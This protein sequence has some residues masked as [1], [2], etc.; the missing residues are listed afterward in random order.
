MMEFKIE[1]WFEL[2]LKRNVRRWCTVRLFKII[3]LGPQFFNPDCHLIE[4][5][6]VS[7][8]LG[9]TSKPFYPYC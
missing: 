9:Y 5:N 6:S 2:D 1:D 8:S 4:C 7:L 3:Y